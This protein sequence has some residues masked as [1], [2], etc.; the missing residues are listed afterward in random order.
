V[1]VRDSQARL[2]NVPP[3][4]VEWWAQ[5]AVRGAGEAN[6]RALE[7]ERRVAELEAALK[8]R[9]E[10]ST[11]PGSTEVKS[12]S[13]WRLRAPKAVAMLLAVL[14]IITVLGREVRAL[15]GLMAGKP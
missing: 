13:G 10:G 11:P 15:W 6:A 5:L 4:D 7:L 12:P 3:S 2:A 8:A 9:G 1:T 14:A